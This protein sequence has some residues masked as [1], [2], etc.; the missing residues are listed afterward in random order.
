MRD[1]ALLAIPSQENLNNVVSGDLDPHDL[2]PADLE[3]AND[4]TPIYPHETDNE[5]CPQVISEQIYPRTDFTDSGESQED[6]TADKEPSH[7]H[8]QSAIQ[9]PQPTPQNLSALG[10]GD[11]RPILPL[12][13]NVLMQADNERPKYLLSNPLELQQD[14]FKSNDLSRNTATEDINGQSTKDLSDEQNL[15]VYSL[16]SNH[17]QGPVGNSHPVDHPSVTPQNLNCQTANNLYSTPVVTNNEEKDNDRSLE[18]SDYN[19]DSIAEEKRAFNLQSHSRVDIEEAPDGFES[20]DR[21]LEAPQPLVN[22]TPPNFNSTRPKKQTVHRNDVNLHGPN[23]APPQSHQSQ[24]IPSQPEP[25]TQHPPRP[26]PQYGGPQYTYPHHD[27]NMPYYPHTAPTPGNYGW[28]PPY[29]HQHPPQGSCNPQYPPHS[30]PPQQP[31][32]SLCA[33]LL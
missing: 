31:T 21:V 19:Y 28:Y 20:L 7:K 26:P 25:L 2:D 33:G 4:I 30:Y 32:V 14:I 17:R 12:G 22:S 3:I 5:N 9:S 10:N 18:L 16:S 6:N 27:R 29:P 24:S 23:S 8:S 11:S 1:D 13:N 15:N